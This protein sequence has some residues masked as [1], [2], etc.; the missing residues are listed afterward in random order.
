MRITFASQF[1]DGAAGIQ[2]ASEQLLEAQRQVSTGKRLDKISVDPSGAATAVAERNALSAVEQYE[3]T[4]DSSA[5][6]LKVIDTVLSDI[7]D[8]LTKA[9]TSAMSGHGT[10]KTTVQRDAAAQELRGL[11]TSLL[12]DL[13]TMFHG[14]YVFSG[15]SSTTKPY[16]EG[17]GG[18]VGPY[19]GSATEMSVDVGDGKT[20][21]VAMDGST[22]A[23]GGASQ[24]LFDTLDDLIAAVSAGNDAAITTGLQELDAAFTRVTGVQSRLGTDMA[25]IDAEKLRLTQV[26]LSTTERLSKVEEANMAE[27][28]TNMSNADAAYRAALGAV[29]TSTRVS[30]LDYLK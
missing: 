9:Q 5:S 10:T 11:K 14:T 13:N 30:L 6:R 20:V 27:A 24:H 12:D 23:Q 21:K 25:A 22:I 2:R 1:R 17:A 7:V 18:V 3:R 15:I 28:I 29:S 16:T 19:A 4:A 26:K 8:K